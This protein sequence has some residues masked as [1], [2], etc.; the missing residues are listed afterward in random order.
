MERD[1]EQNQERDGSQ[2]TRQEAP[3]HLI[4][5]H[6]PEE[7]SKP[8]MLEIKND[9]RFLVDG[10][11]TTDTSKIGQAMVDWFRIR[12][13]AL[14]EKQAAYQ[15]QVEAQAAKEREEA[16]AIP[17]ETVIVEERAAN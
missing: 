12:T 7:P 14:Q 2:Q 16:K 10:I 4:F 8:P 13:I 1:T 3:D 11:V 5:F 15:A 17:T 6:N 9:G